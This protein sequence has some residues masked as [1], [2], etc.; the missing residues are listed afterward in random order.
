MVVGLRIVMVT[1]LTSPTD[2]FSA[3]RSRSCAFVSTAAYFVVPQA[4]PGDIIRLH[5][6]DVQR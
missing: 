3:V 1:G 5:A 6:V 2:S 4:Q